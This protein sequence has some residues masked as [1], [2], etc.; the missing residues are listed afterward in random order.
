MLEAKL[1][2]LRVNLY[3]GP[4]VGK[5]TTSHWLMT[6]LK[7]EGFD[8]EFVQ[9]AVKLW[10]HQGLVPTE[11]DQVEFLAAQMKAEYQWVQAGIDMLVTESPLLLSGVYASHDLAS[12]IKGI[13]YAFENTHPGI[14][15]LLDR[16]D[17]PF[18]RSGR[19][20][21]HEQALALDKK[22]EEE[23]N[24]ML[25]T[26]SQDTPIKARFYDRED[27]WK[28]LLEQMDKYQR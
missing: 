24:V 22:I 23:L 3:G 8:V 12:S 26:L 11:Y 21:T 13:A 16:G 19:F 5:S 2:T 18:K 14:H 4:G 6:K 7:D 28:K 10:A 27:L 17:K 25:W 1:K 15:I 20:Q 9:E